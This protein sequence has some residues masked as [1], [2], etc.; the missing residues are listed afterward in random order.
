MI[1]SPLSGQTR[2]D[3][4]QKEIFIA[5]EELPRPSI[6]YDQLALVLNSSINL[7]DYNPPKENIIYIS[8]IINCKGED[9][10]YKTLK[11]ID[12]NLTDI[13]FKTIKSNLTWIPAKQNKQEV[14]IQKTLIIR[15]ENGKFHIS[16]SNQTT[17]KKR[18]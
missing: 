9:F 3:T 18:K 14:D 1:M 16:D 7:N 10:N 17:S 15:I 4:I 5:T 2:C 13:L 6:S 12:N 8:F 11:P